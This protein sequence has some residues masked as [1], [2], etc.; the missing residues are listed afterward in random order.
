MPYDDN[1]ET[2]MFVEVVEEETASPEAGGSGPFSLRSH[3]YK[4]IYTGGP[5]PHATDVFAAP[6]AEEVSASVSAKAQP[7]V[8]E[9]DPQME[10]KPKR[11][12]DYSAV[13][14]VLSFLLIMAGVVTAIYIISVNGGG[15][16]HR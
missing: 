16:C 14:A 15:F 3:D 13:S 1:A 7:L 10:P 8:A 12:W 9:R 4:P 2:D 6:T 11:R 5:D